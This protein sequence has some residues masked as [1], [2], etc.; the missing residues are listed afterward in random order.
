MWPVCSPF[1]P[2]SRE[3]E[4][5]SVCLQV[6]SEPSPLLLFFYLILLSGSDQVIVIRQNTSGNHSGKIEQNGLPY[7]PLLERK[8]TQLKRKK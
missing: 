5:E 7:T 4:F 8:R 1:V 2:T 3:I 6:H